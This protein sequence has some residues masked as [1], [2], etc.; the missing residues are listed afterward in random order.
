MLMLVPRMHGMNT[1]LALH[2]WSPMINFF[3]LVVF[4]VDMAIQR[5]F[6]HL[7]YV[8][9]RSRR[10]WMISMVMMM[11]ESFFGMMMGV[12]VTREAAVMFGRFHFCVAEKV[13]RDIFWD[14]DWAAYDSAASKVTG[15]CRPTRL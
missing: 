10:V 12:R 6:G 14:F 13:Q 15:R 8:D 7:D 4:G 9:W 11:F 1:I 2:A 5:L 3:N